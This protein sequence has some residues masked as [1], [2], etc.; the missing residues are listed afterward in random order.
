MC[1]DYSAEQ[2]PCPPIQT[3]DSK[4]VS[5]L[6]LEGSQDLPCGSKRCLHVTGTV[7]VWMCLSSAQQKQPLK[8]FRLSMAFNI[9]YLLHISGWLGNSVVTGLLRGTVLVKRRLPKE[10]FCLHYTATYRRTGMIEIRSARL[11]FNRKMPLV[12]AI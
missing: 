6:Q 3:K 11:I 10:L 7:G 12:L 1:I 2:I 8:L 5:V 9:L 4:S